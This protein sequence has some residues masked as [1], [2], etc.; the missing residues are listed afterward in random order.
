MLGP[1]PDWMFLEDDNL[2]VVGNR[3]LLHHWSCQWPSD[4]TEE[5]FQ[6]SSRS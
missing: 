4:Y 5:L 6:L 1:E 3:K 2:F